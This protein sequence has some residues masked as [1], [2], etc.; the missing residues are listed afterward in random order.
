MPGP[1]Q[2]TKASVILVCSF[3]ERKSSFLMVINLASQWPKAFKT[4]RI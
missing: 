1:S 3:S 2:L 4:K